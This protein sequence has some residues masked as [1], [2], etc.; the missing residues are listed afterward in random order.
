MNFWDFAHDAIAPLSA[1][2]GAF[3]GARLSAQSTS[4]TELRALFRDGSDSLQRL[5][6]LLNEARARFAAEGLDTSQRA[7]EGLVELD[8]ERVHAERLCDRIMASTEPASDVYRHF[9]AAL[10]SLET[11][12]DELVFAAAQ[13]PGSPGFNQL[14]SY[15]KVEGGREGLDTERY[16]Y[17]EA[18][19]RR[20]ARLSWWRRL[21]RRRAKAAS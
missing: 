20:I 6:L 11:A 7:R 12:R 9:V 4:D 5:N 13:P 16:A 19:Q 8:E 10:R 14:G 18:I 2:L 17:L 3:A 21:R 1:L 15:S